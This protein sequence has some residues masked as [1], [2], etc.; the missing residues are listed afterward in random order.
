MLRLVLSRAGQAAVVVA[1][2]ATM[3]FVLVHLAPGDPFSN[4]DDP[5]FTG[6]MRARERTRWGYDK[7]LPEQ[8]VRWIGNLARGEF[9]WSHERSRPVSDVLRE[10]LPNTLL[11]MGTALF[12]GVVA[13][14]ALG[15]WQAARHLSPAERASN[16]LTIG[17]LS[18]PEFILSLGVVA[19]FA[20][21][22]RWFPASGMVDPA[23]HESFSAVGRAMDV[24]RHL[25]L[26]AG[27]LAALTAAAVSRYHRTAMLAVLPEEFVRT[28]RAKGASERVAV[29]HHA[30][31]NALGPLIT[32]S[33]LMLPALFGGAVFVEQIFSWPG[34]GL[35]MINAVNGRDYQ[36]VLAGVIVSSV[37]VAA[38][39]ALADVLAVIADPRLRTEA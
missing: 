36:L 26:P 33:G 23:W 30:L 11:L 24:L 7:P 27:T 14:V 19:L 17:L 31:R 12:V 2:V 6:A 5:S 15:T 28:A 13:G 35:T 22:W 21:H 10:T 34:M 32:I 37:L 25:A 38:G 9:G 29:L 39:G 3:A 4:A 16:L 20:G 1:V 18:V 8:Y